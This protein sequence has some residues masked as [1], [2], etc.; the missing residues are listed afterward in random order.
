MSCNCLL[1]VYSFLHV[2]V[3]WF[4]NFMSI[5]LFKL[6]YII[7]L[8]RK[9]LYLETTVTLTII[10]NVIFPSFPFP[11]RFHLL[12]IVESIAVMLPVLSLQ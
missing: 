10:L 9:S 1:S 7:T 12:F 11:M 6:K 3:C 2:F 4:S 5:N 8:L